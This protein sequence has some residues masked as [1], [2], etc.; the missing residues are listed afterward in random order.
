VS[1]AIALPALVLIVT[2]LLVWRLL[3]KYEPLTW[4]ELRLPAD[5]PAA[6]LVG[7]FRVVAGVWEGPVVFVTV[8]EPGVIRFFL[9]APE[10]VGGSVLGSLRGLLPELLAEPADER[11]A[12]GL[13]GGRQRGG[14]RVS[15]RG[16]WPLLRTRDPEIS[17]GGLLGAIG[18]AHG[19]ERVRLIT[20]LWPARRVNRPVPASE[21]GRSA[22]R[23]WWM[24]WLWPAEP[25]RED[26]SVIRTKFSGLLLR[27][28]LLVASE[29]A[30]SERMMQLNQR[31]VAGL[32]AAGGVRGVLAWSRVSPQ[33]LGKLLSRQR[34]PMPWEHS[35]LL[36]PEELV[37][38][39]GLPAGSPSVPGVSYG[40]APRL[41]T[42][43]S[44]PSSGRVFAASTSPSQ[45]GRLIAQ[46]V[47]GGL[48]HTAIIGG[49]GSGK[50]TLASRLIE[51]DMRAGR[52]ALVIDLKGD[53][54]ETCLSLLPKERERDVI[55]MEP[56]RDGLQPG[57]RLF[58]P[59]GDE[60]L[61][62]DLLL[63]TLK[64]LFAESWGVRS[65]QYLALGLRTAARLPGGT[66]ADLPAIFADR[67]LRDQALKTK[68]DPWLS[69]AWQRFDGLTPSD[70]AAQIAAPLTKLEEVVGR[71]RVR[72]VLGQREPKLDFRQVLAGDKL[73][74][75]SLPPGLLGGPAT[76][77]ITATVLWQ[78]FQMVEGRAALPPAARKPF[79]AYIDEVAALSDLPLPLTGILERARSHGVGLTLM[80]QALSQLSPDVR[81]SLLANVGSVAAFKQ[82]SD[83]EAGALSRVLPGVSASQLQ[84]L[85][86]YEIALRL[87]LGPGEVTPVM[88]GK[89]LPPL[90][91]C[92]DPD[93]IRRLS[94]ERYGGLPD[95]AAP[96]EHHKPSTGP[97]G[98][99]R[100]QA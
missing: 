47:K 74:F 24:A 9:G 95:E 48:Q 38:L 15:W 64:E 34:R 17:A 55:V 46:G 66:L 23:P 83:E 88:T 43:N 80:P 71:R 60:E 76:R 10:R 98:V 26:V 21:R 84:H 96:G 49:T 13:Q 50:S 70:Q 53:L 19:R 6:A 35:T 61:T 68:S 2:P 12:I 87:S 99:I 85:G 8:G 72:A 29:A 36:S 58:P 75:V 69:A 42:P 22:Q 31:V 94:S 41:F 90:T 82:L 3:P 77:L 14:V 37:G 59:G 39:I 57:L 100:R 25:P 91:P 56:A 1:V 62:A 81:T 52:G 32:R 18:S 86:P 65:S 78:F 67:Q 5:V 93:E 33:R 7:L 27:T 51:G 30:G 97:L 40:A 44:V 28:E 54:I 89:T 16:P 79:M 63:S 73:V 20:R 4:H 92:S 11:D 45:S